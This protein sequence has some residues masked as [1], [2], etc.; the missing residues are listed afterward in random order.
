MGFHVSWGECTKFMKMVV[1]QGMSY[2]QDQVTVGPLG[3]KYEGP[4]VGL[5]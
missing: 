1:S 5:V 4:F 3:K 2:C